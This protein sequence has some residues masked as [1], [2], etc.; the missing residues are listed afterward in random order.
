MI[1]AIEEM[2]AAHFA[3][4]CRILPEMVGRLSWS[5]EQIMAYQAKALRNLVE[6]AKLQSSW[7]RS[8][9]GDVDPSS[10]TVANLAC[11]PTMTK[12]DLMEHWD[13]IATISGATLA[14]AQ[15]GLQSMKDQFYLWGDCNLFASGGTG[16]RPG[17]FLYDWDGLAQNWAGMCR[18]IRPYVA[19]LPCPGN[20]APQPI[21]MAAIVA[22]MSPHGSFVVG[23]VFSNP[24]NPITKFSGWRS[25]DDLV[26]RLNAAQSE[27]L[28]CYPSLIPALAEAANTGV[29]SIAPDVIMCGGEHFPDESRILARATWPGTTI[30]TC[31][32]TS[33][34][35]GTF[36]CPCGDG[37]HIS[38]DQV[39]IEPVDGAGNPVAP[40][41]RA[42]GIYFTNLYNMAQPIIRYYID[43]AF[44]MADEPCLCGSA[45]RKVRQVHGRS[46]EKF[47][48]GAITVHPVALQLAVLEQPSIIEYNIEQT[49]HGAHLSYAS[50]A[51]VYPDRLVEKMTEALR[52]YGIVEPVVTVA[53]VAR[54]A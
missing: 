49:P 12:S 39:I 51:S 26:P 31:W 8:R 29:L 47:R 45:F 34:G 9:L 40:G 54:V 19:S 21:R 25:V 35:G 4:F 50:Q 43:D 20:P 3:Y 42:A 30:L 44:E 27:F 33:E 7:H 48:Y 28:V 24:L 38:E 14:D 10:L 15:H 17:I 16:G 18:S 36:P 5:R 46:F 1:T 13:E 23:R 2:R 11:L 32:G 41:A 22:E 6:H 37:F 53:H 52:S